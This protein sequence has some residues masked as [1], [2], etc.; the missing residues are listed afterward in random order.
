MENKVP[1]FWGEVKSLGYFL[2]YN[3]QQQ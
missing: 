2:K 3:G 1:M